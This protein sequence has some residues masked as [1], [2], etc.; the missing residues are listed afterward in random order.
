MKGIRYKKQGGYQL[1]ED[2]SLYIPIEPKTILHDTD[3]YLTLNPTGLLTI[4]RGWCWDG[5]SGPTLD[6]KN[7]MRPSLVHDALC[8]LIRQGQ[9]SHKF[10]RK[11]VDILLREM[12]REDGMSWLRSKW[13]Y[14]GVRIGGGTPKP[15]PILEAP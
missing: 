13:V 7:F 2:Y 11:N 8:M 15:R 4:L 3:G 10:N 9:L 1:V 12:C 6:T 5:P 14:A